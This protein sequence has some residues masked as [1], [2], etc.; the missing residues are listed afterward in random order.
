MVRK[1]QVNNPGGILFNHISQNLAYADDV[2]IISR[3]LKNLEEGL[4]RLEKEA[5]KVGLKV[6]AYYCEWDLCGPDQYCCGDNICCNNVYSLWYFWAGII[7]LVIMLS[8]CGG[9][10]FRYCFAVRNQ[11]TVKPVTKYMPLLNEQST[12]DKSRLFDEINYE[13][14][15]DID[16]NLASQFA[17]DPICGHEEQSINLSDAPRGPPPP[18]SKTPVPGESVLKNA[19]W[20]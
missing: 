19:Y 5:E 7:I 14:M 15:N 17:A 10:F 13:I 11:V 12:S 1:T 4:Q 6:T 3:R 16:H 9:G 20:S 8:T 2:D 18:Y